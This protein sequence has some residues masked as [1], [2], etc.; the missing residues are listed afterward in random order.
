MEYFTGEQ[1]DVNIFQSQ[2]RAR[3]C[4]AFLAPRLAAG[5]VLGDD[6]TSLLPA[7]VAEAPDSA[8][9]HDLKLGMRVAQASSQ[10]AQPR[11]D[12]SS[13]RRRKVLQRTQ[14]PIQLVTEQLKRSV[15][16]LAII[17]RQER[18]IS[19]HDRSARNHHTTG[20]L[21]IITRQ[22]RS[23]SSHDRSA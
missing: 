21:A 14:R 8:A 2:G 3:T 19:S 7:V 22:E 4:D 13:V 9:R 11:V 6:V 12:V 16:A 15:S 17:T 23:R 18:S 10:L 1:Y 5:H 20:A